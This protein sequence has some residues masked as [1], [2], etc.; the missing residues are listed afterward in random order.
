MFSARPAC[1]RQLGCPGSPRRP[2]HSRSCLYTETR[3]RLFRKRPVRVAPSR[4]SRVPSPPRLCLLISPS[5]IPP[6]SRDGKRPQKLS[7]SENGG[8]IAGIQISETGVTQL[9]LA[10]RE[11]DET[12]LTRLIPLVHAEL[13]RIARR[14]MRGQRPDH[15]LQA[16]ALVNEAYAT[17]RRP[18]DELAEP[19]AHFLAMAARLMRR[20]LIDSARARGYQKRGGGAVRVSFS[21]ELAVTEPK[22]PRRRP[23]GRCPVR[24]RRFGRQEEPRR[25]TALFRRP[26][27][28]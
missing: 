19:R 6:V 3:C 26:E 9:L 18:A 5:F 27:R 11:G 2:V 25:R 14:C 22:E 28:G 8:R 15:S 10:W 17:G 23:S 16:T 24:P 12:A 20:I 13:Q 21:E 7:S 4:P 1:Q